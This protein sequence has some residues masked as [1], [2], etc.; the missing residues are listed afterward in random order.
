L[1]RA[2]GDCRAKWFEV[3]FEII[4]R[5]N[6]FPSV[7]EVWILA[8]FLRAAAREMFRHCRHGFRSQVLTLE[9]TNIGRHKATCQ[10]CSFAETTADPSPAG[11][12]CK[13]NLR[14]QGKPEA[15]C[16][17]L[18]PS[19]VCKVLHELGGAD[20]GQAQRFRP[21]RECAGR[22]RGTDVLGEVV[23]GVRR[24]RDRDAQPG[25]CG[26]LLQSV[27]P[28]RKGPRVIGGA[29]QVE[30]SD[31]LIGD[32]VLGALHAKCGVRLGKIT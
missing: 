21:L 12:R 17:V 11:L 5:I 4:A 1:R 13:I 26:Q 9:S 20:R 14:M 27:V 22:G 6:L 19:G 16:A 7:R 24:Q 2:G 30:V 31:Q 10:I 23:P 25:T 3:V 28:F 32:H 18:L 29:D 15:H 8:I